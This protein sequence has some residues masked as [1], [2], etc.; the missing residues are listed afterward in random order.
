[1][2]AFFWPKDVIASQRYVIELVA[3]VTMTILRKRNTRRCVV[4][5]KPVLLLQEPLE[6]FKNLLLKVM[7]H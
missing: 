2:F 5:I 6:D 7:F 4:L 1:M 3:H